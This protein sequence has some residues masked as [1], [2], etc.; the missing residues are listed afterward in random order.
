MEPFLR[1]FLPTDKLFYVPSGID[2]STFEN[3]CE[4]RLRQV[5]MIGNLRWQKGYPYALEAFVQ[6]SQRHPDWRLVIAGDGSLGD[7]L[8]Q[9]AYRLG[10]DDKVS[11]L[12]TISR[13]DIVNLLNRSGIFFLSSVSEGFPKVIL[14]AMACGTPIVA[15]DAGSCAEVIPGAGIVVT[16]KDVSAMA[17]ALC[18]LVDDTELWRQC[19]ETAYVRARDYE[20]ASIAARVEEIYRS[21][22]TTT[23]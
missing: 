17:M 4:R 20:W 14:E 3:R 5:C 6:F 18:Q 2:M 8:R 9:L 23:N 7:E 10:I 22:C 19:S 15:T 16:S 1:S 13:E 21:L 11:F 12:G